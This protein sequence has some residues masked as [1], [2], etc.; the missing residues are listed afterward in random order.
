MDYLARNNVTLS[1][2]DTPTYAQHATVRMFD[3]LP[4][5]ASV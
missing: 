4:L 5:M 2:V 1:M 3:S